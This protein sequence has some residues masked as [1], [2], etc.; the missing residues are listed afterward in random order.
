MTSKDLHLH[1]GDPG[2]GQPTQGNR[3]GLGGPQAPREGNGADQPGQEPAG[4]DDT[5]MKK[6]STEAI[7]PRETEGMPTDDE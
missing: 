4:R 7:N 3:K 6:T 1:P 2:M 5:A